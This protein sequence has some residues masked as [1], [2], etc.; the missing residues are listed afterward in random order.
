[1]SVIDDCIQDLQNQ[2]MLHDKLEFLRKVFG[3]E[4]SDDLDAAFSS[5]STTNATRRT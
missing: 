5:T 1:M 3:I 2:K 4:F